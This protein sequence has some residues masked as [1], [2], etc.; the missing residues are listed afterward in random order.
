M[1]EERSRTKVIDPDILRPFRWQE[2]NPGKVPEF[3]SAKQ[4]M[5]A[6]LVD[7]L[8][9]LQ[10]HR[11]V[12]EVEAWIAARGDE[13]PFAFETICDALGIDADYLRNGLSK[14]HC[15]QLNGTDPRRT[16]KR[17]SFKRQ[18]PIKLSVRR[19]ARHAS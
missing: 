9:C 17:E 4:L 13:E 2:G 3:G 10:K 14:W 1:S 18:G 12:A 19:R 6:V 8:R 16:V 5:L 15:Q 7:A 11:R